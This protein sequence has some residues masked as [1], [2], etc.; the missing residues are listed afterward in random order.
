MAIELVKEKECK[1]STQEMYDIIAFSIDAAEDDGFMNSFIF[2]RAIYLF[3]AII[4]YP[5]HKEEFSNLV[6]KN[7]NSAWDKMLSDG[8]ID[9]MI[10][11]FPTELEMLAENGKIWF[12]E[13]VEYIHSARGLLNSAQMF[14]G[15]IVRAAADQFKTATVQSG[16]EEVLQI[17]DKWG[18]NNADGKEVVVATTQDVPDESLIES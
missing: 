7:I 16:V 10:K 11:D 8:I 14:T 9:N 18:M 5:D 15:D 17:A 12:D 3:A 6:A 2:N 13:Y 4:L 1:L